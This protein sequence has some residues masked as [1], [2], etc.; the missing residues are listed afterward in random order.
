[1]QVGTLT[2]CVTLL[3]AFM[4]NVGTLGVFMPIALRTAA[5][6][7][8][9]PSIYLMPLAFGSLIGGTITQIGTSPNLLISQVR[10]D[11]GGEA[12]GMFDFTPVGLPLALL[13][14][15]FL[16]VG[17]RLI[18]RKDAALRADTACEGV[19]SEVTVPADSP[20]VGRTLGQMEE[21]GAGDIVTIE[22]V[23]AAERHPAPDPAIPIEGGDLLLLQVDPVALRPLLESGQLALAAARDLP[24]APGPGGMETVE[25]VVLTDSP[26]VGQSA[27]SLCL[28]TEHGVNL[29]AIGRNGRRIRTRLRDTRLRSG[30]LLVL[31]GRGFALADTLTVLG[32]LP[33]SVRSLAP[34][35]RRSGAF[36]LAILVVVLV[37]A[38]TRML[39]VDLAFF[40]GAVA[41][42][43]VGAVTPG[44]AYEA[45]DWPIVVM[46]GCLIPVGEALHRTGAADLL[47]A[48][49]SS[50]A[51]GLPPI[52]ALG[53][54]LVASMAVTP[55]LHHA[56]AV[57]VMGPMAAAVAGNLGLSQD[58]FLMAVALGASCDF[59]T[60]IG[61]QN[62]L[63]VMGP[64]GYSFGDYWRLGLP[65]SVLVAVMGTGLI[66]LVWGV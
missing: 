32:C 23:R 16:A 5:R 20:L 54:M 6:S 9:S 21:Q 22:L 61:H 12:F 14:T 41:V 24:P 49:L 31:Q 66:A 18:P 64:G 11:L 28:R 60:P 46:L 29:L 56:A 2:A 65:L 40:L 42:V 48:L 3:S 17:W 15:V 33:V 26:L 13:A 27:R 58:A 62:N 43:V 8:R 39:P 45:I 55:F 35:P 36:S 53:L 10:R 63:L 34:R 37:L 59:L 25:A 38:S 47:G 4:K 30:D 1:M 50:L 19:T 7:E 44:E 52:L 51:H 57:V